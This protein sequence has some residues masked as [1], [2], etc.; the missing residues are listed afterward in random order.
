M[1]PTR[2]FAA[3]VDRWNAGRWRGCDR[4]GSA[5]QW[6]RSTRDWFGSRAARP[7]RPSPALAENRRSQR[8]PDESGRRLQSA[9]AH[10]RVRRGHACSVGLAAGS[11]RGRL[12]R[13]SPLTR[14]MR[15]GVLRGRR[16]NR[17]ADFS[18]PRP[19]HA[20]EEETRSPLDPRH[21]VTRASARRLPPDRELDGADAVVRGGRRPVT[22]VTGYRLPRLRRC[23]R[24]PLQGSRVSRGE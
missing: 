6:C 23:D 9:S 12:A 16:M 15:I 21:A 17:G 19:T 1:E 5:S 13:A 2:S 10:S 4:R 22:H 3:V 11:D 20:S 18:R 24:S 7:P 8:P 14:W